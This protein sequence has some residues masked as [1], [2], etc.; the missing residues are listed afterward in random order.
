MRDCA[1]RRFAP[2]SGPAQ[3][4]CHWRAPTEGARL[5][6][7]LRGELKD[8]P[9]RVAIVSAIGVGL[10]SAGFLPQAWSQSEGIYTCVDSKG[11]RLTADRPIAECTDR[12]QKELNPSGTV[13]RQVG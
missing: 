6:S 5:P 8:Q 2:V 9:L 7:A 13:K 1:A 4:R 10:L 12:V 11:R 3:W